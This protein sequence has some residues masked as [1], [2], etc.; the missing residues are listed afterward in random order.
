M[1]ILLAII[2]S[3][4]KLGKCPST[5]GWINK[6]WMLQNRI[7]HITE[8][9]IIVHAA[10]SMKIMNMVLSNEASHKRD[11]SIFVYN[12]KQIKYSIIKIQI[13]VLLQRYGKGSRMGLSD[14]FKLLNSALSTI[15]S[16]FRKPHVIQRLVPFLYF[17]KGWL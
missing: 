6:L 11:K 16:S 12:L 13:G 15:L 4:R 14:I 3:S 5:V 10:I 1:F 8:K 9:K 2:T 7:P 17:F